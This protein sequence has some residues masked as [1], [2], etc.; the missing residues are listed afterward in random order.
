[1]TLCKLNIT[2]DSLTYL[3]IDAF[4]KKGDFKSLQMLYSEKKGLV[5]PRDFAIS[6]LKLNY[7]S[8]S[9]VYLN[10]I[11]DVKEKCDIL[12]DMKLFREAFEEA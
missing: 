12:I 6:C 10:Y 3:K 9:K 7:V 11:S 1:M 8:E 5:P 2:S 4:V